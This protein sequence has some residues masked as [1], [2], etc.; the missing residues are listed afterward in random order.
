MQF[1]YSGTPLNKGQRLRLC[2]GVLGIS[3]GISD[4][5]SIGIRGYASCTRHVCCLW[6]STTYVSG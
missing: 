5:I 3:D 4:G 6:L 1:A 2:V